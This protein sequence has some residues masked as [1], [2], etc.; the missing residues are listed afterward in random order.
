MIC[1]LI[2]LKVILHVL[3]LFLVILNQIDTWNEE[4]SISMKWK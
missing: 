1:L 4:Y 2:E 3:L